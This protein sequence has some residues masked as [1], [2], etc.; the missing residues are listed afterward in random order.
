MK[1]PNTKTLTKTLA[2]ILLAATALTGAERAF[3]D[4]G[5]LHL[6]NWTDYT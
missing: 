6:Y 5:E 3:A 1:T 2:G 4:G